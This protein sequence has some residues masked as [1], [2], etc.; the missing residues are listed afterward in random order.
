LNVPAA[1]CLSECA[2]WIVASSRIT[3]VFP[4]ST[5]ATREDGIRPCRAAISFHTWRRIF[6]RAV[7]IRAR[8]ASPT[9][10]RARHS[11]A[12]EATGPNSSA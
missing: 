5:S 1:P 4:R 11:V 8:W 12:S 3:T 6:A 10:S 2:I 9:S 7:A